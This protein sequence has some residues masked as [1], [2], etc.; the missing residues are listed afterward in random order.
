MSLALS[1]IEDFVSLSRIKKFDFFITTATFFCLALITRFIR[2]TV[3]IHY[4]RPFS[5]DD[6]LVLIGAVCLIAAT[7]LT[8]SWLDNFYLGVVLAKDVSFGSS[9]APEELKSFMNTDLN[10]LFVSTMVL[11]WTAIFCVKGSFLTFSRPIVK[12]VGTL[13]TY[14]II[15]TSAT[16]VAWAYRVVQLILKCPK[17][18][19]GPMQCFNRDE[20]LTGGTSAAGAAV[21]VFTSFMML[22]IPT[23]LYSYIKLSDKQRTALATFYIF[24]MVIIVVTILP[25]IDLPGAVFQSDDLPWSVFWSHTGASMA[26]ILASLSAF[27]T[28]IVLKSSDNDAPKNAELERSS[29]NVWWRMSTGKS[30]EDALPIAPKAAILATTTLTRSEQADLERDSRQ[31]MSRWSVSTLSTRSSQSSIRSKHISVPAFEGGSSVW[32]T[33]LGW[34]HERRSEEY[35]RPFS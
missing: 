18:S 23:L 10:A 1:S 25:S 35:E 22:S 28:V 5:L 9:L 31:A 16:I 6:C 17:F 19:E 15:V 30:P 14:Y 34:V 20:Q 27:Q 7:G 8:Y 11:L 2:I 13:E 4:R 21:D 29:Q 33:S 26:I 12:A 32:V 3:K 24:V